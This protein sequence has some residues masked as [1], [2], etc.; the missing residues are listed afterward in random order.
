MW[1]CVK[2]ERM[3]EAANFWK[4]FCGFTLSDRERKRGC[5]YSVR[6]RRV[7]GWIY[8]VELKGKKKSEKGGVPLFEC[9]GVGAQIDPQAFVGPYFPIKYHHITLLSRRMR[10]KFVFKKI[11]LFFNNLCTHKRI[12]KKK[13]T[14]EVM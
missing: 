12:T 13:S 4:T 2:F 5:V 3:D 10:K 11:F 6:E 9:G 8:W 14:K 1:V 7:N